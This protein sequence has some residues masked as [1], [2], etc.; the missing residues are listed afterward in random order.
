MSL[1]TLFAR[2]FVKSNYHTISCLS[3]QEF[4][5]N[6]PKKKTKSNDGFVVCEININREIYGLTSTQ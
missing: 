4:N 2:I 5:V 3:P 1:L 6:S